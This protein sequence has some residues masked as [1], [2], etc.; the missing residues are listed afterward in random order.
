[1]DATGRGALAP[2]PE[3]THEEIQASQPETIEEHLAR[4]HAKIAEFRE[5]ARELLAMWDEPAG[6]AAHLADMICRGQPE[7]AQCG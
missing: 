2:I 4:V 1:M 6:V 3:A 5:V 7:A